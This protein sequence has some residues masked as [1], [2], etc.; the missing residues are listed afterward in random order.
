MK[1]LLLLIVVILSS[2]LGVVEGFSQA[3]TI[4]M[5]DT[6]RCDTAGKDIECYL[7][8]T[9]YNSTPNTLDIDVVRVQN[10]AASGWTTAFCLNVCYLPTKDSVRF[11]LASNAHQ[12]F[13]LHFYTTTVD[14]G[15]C[16]FK[17]KNVS[18]PSNT[19][20]QR[21]YCSTLCVAGVNEHSTG[22]ANVKIYPSPVMA[23]ENFSIAISSEKNTGSMTLVFYNIYGSAVSTNRVGQ[24]I[25]VMNL[26]LPAG[27]Y[28]YD[29][30]S[31]NENI[32][33]GKMC[34]SR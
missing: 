6:S 29:L 21:Y 5:P 7:G 23:G 22:K 12:K 30:I 10:V 32:S 34:V 26:D 16:Y 31:G 8:D 1:K 3:L 14:S 17:F 11:S 25:N 27:V 9:I 2:L 19:L 20:Y 15:T 4:A 33:S 18:T 24:G 13:I 28:S